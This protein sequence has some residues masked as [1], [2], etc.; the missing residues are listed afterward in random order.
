LLFITA[1]IVS[2]AYFYQQGTSNVNGFWGYLASAISG[3]SIS[4]FPIFIMIGLDMR[5]DIKIE[6]EK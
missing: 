5:S 4:M 6:A 3:I 1:N 2:A